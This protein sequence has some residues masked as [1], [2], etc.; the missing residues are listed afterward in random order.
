MIKVIPEMNEQEFKIA[1][2]KVIEKMKEEYPYLSAN[3]VNVARLFTM[4]FKEEYLK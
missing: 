3:A 4:M 1:V 2:D